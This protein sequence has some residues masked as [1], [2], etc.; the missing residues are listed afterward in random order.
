MLLPKEKNMETIHLCDLYMFG[1]SFSGK[2]IGEFLNLK[3]IKRMM[4]IQVL[5]ICVQV[6]QLRLK[7]LT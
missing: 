7:N 4:N 2:K 3:E 5:I 1:Y 6:F